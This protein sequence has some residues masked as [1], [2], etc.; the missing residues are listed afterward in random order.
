MEELFYGLLAFAAMVAV[1]LVPFLTY[2]IVKRIEQNQVEGLSSL[3][4]EMRQIRR[5]VDARLSPTV[6]PASAAT[7]SSS[8]KPTASQPVSKPSTESKLPATPI[9]KLPTPVVLTPLEEPTSFQEAISSKTSEPRIR[10]PQ[11]VLTPVPPREPNRFEVAAKETLQKIWNWI[12]VGEEQVPQGV[13]LEYAVASQWLLRIGVLILVVG[14]G[15]FLKYS[16]ERGLL[17][18]QARVALST[19]TGLVLL[20]AGTRILGKKYHIFGQGLMGAG[21]ATLYFS[22]FAASNLFHLIRPASSF[23]LM[24]IVTL[25]AGGIAVRFNSILV[26]VLGILGGYLTPLMLQTGTVDFVGLFG[27]LL[28]LGIGVLGICAWKNWPIVNLLS[29]FGTYALFFMAMRQY[30]VG[31]F[32]EVFPFLVAFFVLFSTMTFLYKIVRHNKSNLLDLIAMFGNAAVFFVVGFQLIDEAYGR[33]WTAVLSLGLTA[34]Y[35]AHIYQF[36]RRKLV[37]RELLVSFFGLATFF[38]AITMPLVLSREWLTASWAIQAVVLLW[39]AKKL[40]SNFVQQT[41][42][43]LFGIVL[44]RFCFY[45][46]GRQFSSG[47]V[48]SHLSV[49]NYLWLL[50]DRLIAFGIPIASFGLAYRLIGASPTTA[51]GEAGAAPENDVAPW[52]PQSAALRGLVFAAI[53]MTFLYLHME[54]NRTV[55]HF[56]RPARLPVLTLLWLALCGFLML[57]TV[58]RGGK[59]LLSLL[60]LALTGVL[61]KLFLFDLPAWGMSSDLLYAAPYSFRDASMRLLDFG[62]IVGFFGGSYALVAKH[63]QFREVRNVLGFASLAMLFIYLTLEVNSYLFHYY[64]GLRAGGVSILW[65]LFAFA[66]ISQGIQ[67]RLAVLRY[68]GLALFAIVSAKVFFV[69]LAQLDQFWRIIAFLLLGILLMAGSFMYLR[70]QDAFKQTKPREHADRSDKEEM[71]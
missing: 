16:I 41:A 29:F 44:A 9:P 33:Q 32:R 64:P 26:A 42:F 21:L 53:G 45:D 70:Y 52:F 11:P 1:F 61:A 71:E 19:I 56:Y 67:K 69:D 34:F 20:I 13:S 47:G 3:R 68:L 38:L 5:R 66:L 58:R 40:K 65:A 25:L 24:G 57:E 63:K 23:A 17:G 2:A 18:P 59:L 46:L 12:I 8:E 31:H 50:A 22:V 37:D 27:Y 15:F 6:D 28:V 62:A 60:S 39:V 35:T 10:T 48:A 30:E 55:G 49:G 43:L 7:A 36:F 54:L 14:V 4:E 51:E